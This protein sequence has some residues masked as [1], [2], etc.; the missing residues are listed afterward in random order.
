MTFLATLAVE[1]F[2]R[3]R[4]AGVYRRASAVAFLRFFPDAPG[5]TLDHYSERSGGWRREDDGMHL[6]RPEVPAESGTGG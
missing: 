5:S 3:G 1:M 6:V 4:S 2:R